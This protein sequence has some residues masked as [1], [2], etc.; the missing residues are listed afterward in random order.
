MILQKGA[1]MNELN[2][3]LFPLLRSVLC[4]E[5][6]DKSIFSNADPDTFKRLYLLSKKHD[7]AHLVSTAID[8]AQLQ[9]DVET[10]KM[11]TKQQMLAVYRYENII[12]E[13]NQVCK[14]LDEAGIPY[15]LLKG[16]V[17]RNLYPE[18]W[19]RTSCDIDVLVKETDV[20][21]AAELLIKTLGYKQ[22]EKPS[23]HDVP[24]YSVSGMHIELH[25]N[26]NET[27]EEIDRVLMRVWDYAVPVSKNA[28]EHVLTKEFFI[29]HFVAHASYHFVNGGCGL[30]TIFDLWLLCQKWEYD[31]N[32]V[33]E[34]CREGDLERFYL[35]LRELSEVWFGDCEHNKLTQ[36]TEK[37]ILSG[38]TYGTQEAKIAATQEAR[39]GKIGYVLSR[40]FVSYEHLKYK[41]PSLK[42]KTISPIYQV[43]RWFDVFKEKKASVYA[44]ELNTTTRLKSEKIDEISLLMKDLNLNKHI[45]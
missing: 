32:K 28:S 13:Q 36:K 10:S 33:I 6:L 37:Y 23:F 42:C 38:G 27:I 25:F 19:M 11:F 17:I 20:D 1:Q 4:N 8:K 30:R 40:M 29:Y 12:F 41:Y 16:A 31:E 15:I 3:I 2:S 43:R 45:K 7:L 18:P 22:G 5:E 14:T 34:L 44:R 26:I 24:L 21:R 35:V 39:R 9:P